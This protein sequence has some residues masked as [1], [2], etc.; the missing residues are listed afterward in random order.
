MSMTNFNST[1]AQCGYKI[2][3]Y[4]TMNIIAIIICMRHYEYNCF[5]AFLFTSN[6]PQSEHKTIRILVLAN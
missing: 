2:S 1:V 6:N 4:S 3:L 5:Y